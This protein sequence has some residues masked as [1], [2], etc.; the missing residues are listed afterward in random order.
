MPT[1]T[2]TVTD[3]EGHVSAP[4][5]ASWT[6]QSAAK[7]VIGYWAPAASYSSRLATVGPAGVKA[8]RIYGNLTTAGTDMSSQIVA[9]HN[10]GMMPVV[11][12][13]LGSWSIAQGQSGAADAAADA[14]AAYL[15]SFN[16]P[17][18][19][20]I[21]HEPYDDMSGADFVALQRRLVPFFKRGLLTVGPILHGWLL[22]TAA[23]RTVFGTYLADD[24]LPVYDYAGIDSYQTG[25]ASSPGSTGP[26]DRIAPLLSLL[27]ARGVP[28]IPIGVGE[29]N[30]F[31][32]AML[33]A[34]SETFLS[35][36]NL[37][38]ACMWDSTSGIAVQLSGDR[39][40]AF[41]ETK[42]DARAQQ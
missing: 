40:T 26:G 9:A 36:P 20:A 34:A 16:K 10:A 3:A 29:Y 32:A 30:A 27:S 39:L 17:T 37:A 28:N 31:T 11:S 38:W 21:W 24:L 5:S 4:A 15:A 41:Q 8:R 18:A 7:K 35:T 19:V 12:Y 2:V 13:K 42:A 23:N 33:R 22:D 14:T 6:V 25:S 1:V